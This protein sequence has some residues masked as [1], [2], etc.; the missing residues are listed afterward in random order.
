MA[1]THEFVRAAFKP[2]GREY[3]YMATP[4][5][6]AVGDQAV[7]PGGKSVTV[8]AVKTSDALVNGKPLPPEAYGWLTKKPADP[9]EPVQ[10]EEGGVRG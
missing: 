7:T 3:T 2:G 5:Q 10:I 1:N 9:V 4:D 6:L 8:T